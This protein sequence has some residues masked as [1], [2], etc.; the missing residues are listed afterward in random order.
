MFNCLFACLSVSDNP[1]YRE[2]G[3]SQRSRLKTMFTKQ[4]LLHIWLTLSNT[5]HFKKIKIN[6]EA[7]MLHM[8]TKFF[9]NIDFSNSEYTIS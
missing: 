1:D 5:Q 8:L 9:T 6:D 3:L 7:V 4:F 2:A